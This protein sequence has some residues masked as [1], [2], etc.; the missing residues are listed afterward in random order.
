MK[1]SSQLFSIICATTMLILAPST[2]EAK[3][4]KTI[5][6]IS[7]MPS[8]SKPIKKYILKPKIVI[9]NKVTYVV[10]YIKQ[11]KVVLVVSGIGKINAAATTSLLIENFHPDGVIMCGIAGGI[12]KKLNIGD[13]V[14]GTALYSIEHLTIGKHINLDDLVPIIRLPNPN[15]LRE[16]N[17]LADLAEKNIKT[18]QNNY[19]YITGSIATTDI[20]PSTKSQISILAKNKIDAIDMESFAVAQVGWIF[21]TPVLS[22]KGISD[23]AFINTK[24]NDRMHDG[25]Q[26]HSKKIAENNSAKFVIH[27]LNNID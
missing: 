4:T 26:V 20:Y 18:Y 14:V 24:K 2:I 16:N 10:G 13:V 9:I 8:E 1:I 11:N 15:I 17:W 22:V 25:I 3:T 7:A 27:M 19:K 21:K 12:N 5:G 6:I 23:N